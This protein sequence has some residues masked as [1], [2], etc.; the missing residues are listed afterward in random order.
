[1]FIKWFS[2]FAG[3]MKY[4]YY[5]R[6][7]STKTEG[8]S[9]KLHWDDTKKAVAVLTATAFNHGKPCLSFFKT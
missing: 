1:M 4:L 7:F 2:A 3:F 5:S 8:F 9:A 6:D